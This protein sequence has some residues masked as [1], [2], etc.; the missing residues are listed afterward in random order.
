MQALLRQ[1]QTVFRLAA[2]KGVTQKVIH[3]ETGLSVSVIGQYARG[4]TAMSAASL[5]KMI[6]V[7]PDELL[8]LLLPDGRAIVSMPS[9]INHDEICEWAEKFAARKMAAHREDSPM[10]PVIAPC[11]D[12]DL[13]SIV[14][15]F[16]VGR[17]A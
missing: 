13:K 9:E 16:P 6:G 17:A 4:E 1:Q 7:I 14:V 11:E 12:D 5:I 8:S 10:G 15:A 3:L 2:T